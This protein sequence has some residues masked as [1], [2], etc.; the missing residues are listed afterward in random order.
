MKTVLNV[1]KI[2]CLAALTVL[3]FACEGPEGPIGPAGPA[4]PQGE[5]GAQGAQGEQGAQGD[6]GDQG[7]PGPQGPQGEEGNANVKS[8]TYSI[9]GTDWSAFSG[10]TKTANLTVPAIDQDIV[11]NGA[12]HVY[13]GTGGGYRALPFTFLVST[14]GLRSLFYLYTAGNVELEYKEQGI[15]GGPS[16]FTYNGTFKVVVVEGKAGKNSPDINWDSYEEVAKFYG[17]SLK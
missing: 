3:F 17:F 6:K 9:S 8:Y 2:A 15:S 10:I 5:Q 1:V 11:D 16:T 13:W 12:V 14:G 7:D 4:G